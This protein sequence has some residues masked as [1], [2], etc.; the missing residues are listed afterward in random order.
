M[1]NEDNSQ[2][3]PLPKNLSQLENSQ[4]TEYLK[5]FLEMTSYRNINQGKP[6]KMLIANDPD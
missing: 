4:L 3:N 5:G 2:G 6:L 1:N